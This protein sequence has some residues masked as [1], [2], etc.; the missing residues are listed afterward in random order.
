[1]MVR[2]SRKPWQNCFGT[3]LGFAR[4][5]QYLESIILVL[6]ANLWPVVVVTTDYALNIM[7]QPIVV[8][9]RRLERADSTKTCR[10]PAPNIGTGIQATD[11]GPTA[12]D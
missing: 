6:K 3:G 10:H 1:M 7:Q 2:A 11:A 12:L 4:H 5:G 8:F 9:S